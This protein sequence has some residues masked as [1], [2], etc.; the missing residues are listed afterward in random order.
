[1]TNDAKEVYRRKIRA[2]I[3]AWDLEIGKLKDRA[4]LMEPSVRADYVRRVKTLERRLSG[5]ILCYGELLLA[6]RKEWEEKQKA[7]D[8]ATDSVMEALEEFTPP[9]V[10]RASVPGSGLWHVASPAPTRP[11]R[12][13]GWQR[14]HW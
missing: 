9:V 7:L 12:T 8:A 5:M 1:M 14:K 3:E 13:R 11:V 2:R 10:A 6:S 4:H